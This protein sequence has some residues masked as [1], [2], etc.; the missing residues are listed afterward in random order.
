MTVGKSRAGTQRSTWL[1]SGRP[2]PCAGARGARGLP[3]L[4]QEEAEKNGEK[5]FFLYGPFRC[6]SILG[7]NTPSIAACLEDQRLLDTLSLGSIWETGRPACGWM[8]RRL[9]VGQRAQG[10]AAGG[11]GVSSLRGPRVPRAGLQPLWSKEEPCGVWWKWWR[12]TGQRRRRSGAELR[13]RERKRHDRS[14]KERWGKYSW[15]GPWM[16]PRDTVRLPAAPEG[17]NFPWGSRGD[18]GHSPG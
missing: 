12:E 8:P 13:R 11:R 5:C 3:L 7:L 6:L 17:L 2:M 9:G 18:L 4:T 1:Q 16:L 10:R 14:S 15:R